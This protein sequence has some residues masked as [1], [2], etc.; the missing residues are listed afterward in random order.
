[1]IT[2]LAELQSALRKRVWAG[3]VLYEGPSQIDGKPIVVIANRIETKS[4]NDKTGNMVQTWI[5]RSD[6]APTEALKTGDDASV[7]GN[8]RHRPKKKGSCYVV[9]FRAP[10]GVWKAFHNGRYARPGIDFDKR[11]V[12][13]LFAGKA[14]RMGSYGDPAAAPFRVWRSATLNAD[15]VNGYSHQWRDPRF[16]AFKLLCMASADTPEDMADAHALGWRTF[17]VRAAQEPVVKGLEAICPAS[18]EAGY[19]TDCATCK[20]CGG[21]SAKARVSMVI[22]AHG[23]MT[24]R[25]TNER[26][27]L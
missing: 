15:V 16:Q 13:G 2:T 4:T 24:K 9:V 20:S 17:R 25:F 10:L 27:G 14:F 19:K 11:L 12:F 26:V 6:I 8:C 7:C 22:M 23:A 1:M 21:N 5:M 18:K 3:V